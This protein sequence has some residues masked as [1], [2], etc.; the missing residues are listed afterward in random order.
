MT[1]YSLYGKM[2]LYALLRRRSRMLVALL[3]VA[4]G[5][6]VL[7]GLVTLYYDVPRQMGREFRSYGA[8]LLLLPAGDNQILREQAVQQAVGS[9]PQGKV[10][11]LAPYLYDRVKVNAQPVL[12]AGTDFAAVQKVSPYWQLAGQWPAP[13][14]G[15][16]VVGAEVAERL[17]LEP[18][19]TVAVAVPGSDEE[20]KLPVAGIV[21]T[22][23]NEEDFI[24]MELPLL[25][26][27]LSKPGQVSVA[28][29]SVQAGETE[30]TAWLQQV[31]DAVPGIMPRLVKQLTQSEGLVLG[32]L[33]ALV[34]LVTLIV[35]LLTLICVATTMM[36]VVTERRKEIGLKKALGA[37][38]R[39]IV[40][41]FLGEG[42]ALGGL[43]GLLGTGCG[44]FFAQTVSIQVFA[45]SISFQPLVALAAFIVA[46]AVAGLACLI[47]VRMATHVEPAIVLR[48]E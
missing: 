19:Q 24:F 30:L 36:A 10:I 45:R 20:K 47:P 35:L 25:Q 44:F 23:G 18:G 48:G 34:Y 37:E 17:R 5:A 14:S 41:E 29:V 46:V 4:I 13:G 43:G 38:N 27:W 1:K 11:G 32:K 33:Q 21:H 40:L 39:S 6:T 31:T 26:Q 7:S 15:G 22:G 16:V 9:L 2:V 28:Q 42:I 3:A 8:N 12:A